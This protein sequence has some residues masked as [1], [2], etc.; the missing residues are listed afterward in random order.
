MELEEELIRLAPGVLRYCRGR[1]G[2]PALAEEASQ[3]ALTA[4]VMRWRRHGPP[5]SPAAFAFTVARR[6]S[7]RLAW[8]RRLLS[9]FETGRDSELVERG[10]IERRPEEL[11][12]TRERYSQMRRALTR[13]PAR[14]R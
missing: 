7:A 5:D 1:L 4:L 2:D 12:E 13:L 11:Y 14:D 8:R 6:R 10:P 3:E 9:P